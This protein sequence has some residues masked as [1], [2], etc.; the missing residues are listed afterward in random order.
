MSKRPKKAT[1]EQLV[2]ALEQA[3]IAQLEAEI[4]RLCEENIRRTSEWL[5]VER[6]SSLPPH[7]IT[8]ARAVHILAFRAIAENWNPFGPTS[9]GPVSAGRYRLRTYLK[10]ILRFNAA[11]DIAAKS[12]ALCLRDRLTALPLDS[13]RRPPD[14]NVVK[15]ERAVFSPSG[16]KLAAYRTAAEMTSSFREPLMEEHFSHTVV[17]SFTEFD[18]WAVE[19][20]IA[21]QGEL[22]GL[23]TACLEEGGMVCPPSEIKEV[24]QAESKAASRRPR[25]VWDNDALRRLLD[26]SNTYGMTQQK[27]AEKYGVTRPRI[28][29]LL[30]RARLNS[31]PRKASFADSLGGNRKK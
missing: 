30:K 17:V 24:Q 28:S 26:E 16:D 31:G 20:G 10:A 3:E 12:G 1:E 15:W 27:L 14:D 6:H 9:T 25:N 4:D 23:N 21:A 7:T 19:Q 2:E 8:L 5:A 13:W 11:I 29:V 18:A 22:A